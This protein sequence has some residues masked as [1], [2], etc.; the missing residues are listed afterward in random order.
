MPLGVMMIRSAAA[1]PQ[2]RHK[3]AAPRPLAPRS[4]NATRHLCDDRVIELF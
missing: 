1:R 4:V 3:N 2:N